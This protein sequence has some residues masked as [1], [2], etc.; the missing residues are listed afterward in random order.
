VNRTAVATL[1]AAL[2][3]APQVVL[4]A[5]A[6]PWLARAARLSPTAVE[7]SAEAVVLLDDV[8]VTVADDG[9]ITTRRT[10]AVR[11]LTRG[12]ADAASMRE[13]YSTSSGSVRTM[14]GWLLI[15]GR[16]LELGRSE[17]ADIA[18]VDNDVYNE[19]RMK[20]LSAPD[21][22]A[23]GIVFGGETE[24]VERSVFTQL[25]WALQDEWPVRTVRRSLSLPPGWDARAVTFNHRPLDA[26]RS[27]ATLVWEL[28]DLAP[29]PDEPAG[30]A[31]SGLVP[32]L[33]VSYIPTRRDLPGFDDWP[34]VSRWLATLADPQAASHATLT[35]KTKELTASAGS[36][37]ERIRAVARY[38]QG[39][40]YISIQTGIGRGGGYTPH[41][42]F[43]VFTKNYGDCKDKANL[44]RT[45]LASIGLRAYLVTAYSGDPT[46]V[47]TE[48]PSPQQFNHAIVAVVV[49]AETRA[50]AVLEHGSLGRLLFFDPTDEQT[51]LGE[52]PMLLQGSQGLIV[53]AAGGPLVRMPLSNAEANPTTRRVDASVT[54]DGTLHATIRRASAGHP[55]SIQRQIFREL[56]KDDYLHALEADVRR[57]I[58]GAVLSV[59]KVGEDAATNRFELTMTLEAP[60]YAQIVQGRLM[61]VRPPQMNRLDLPT[62]TASV[63]RT[64]VLL[65]PLDERDILELV[66]PANAVVDEVPEPQERRA[67]F[68]SFSIRWQAQSGRVT[69]TVTLQIQRATVAPES[70]SDVRTFLDAFRDAERLPVVLTTR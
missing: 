2:A 7:S 64:P 39:I 16:T 70:Y 57:Q 40:Q 12:G 43:E 34:S 25:E 11:I 9:R 38:V 35:A 66:L 54:A 60:G 63:R 69:R 62:L 18:L 14:R 19:S 13:I 59:G 65:D 30:P 47:R 46:Y 56:R 41:L 53:S 8:S 27:G 6:P 42:A 55:A 68:G 61:I 44:M 51:P 58:P 32:R 29:V 48:W 24:V 4:A 49:G 22:F 1:V 21:L 37:I 36:E 28:H 67:S 23:P 5:D 31:S 10:Y 20:V 15:D 17:T 52:L 50:S 26:V 45:M 3:L 33:A